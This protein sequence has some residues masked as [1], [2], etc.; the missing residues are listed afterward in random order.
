MIADLSK[1]NTKLEEQL[2]VLRNQAQEKNGGAKARAVG[3][4]SFMLRWREGKK[5]PFEMHRSCDAVVGN[6]IVYCK[7]KNLVNAYHIPSSS[8]SPSPKLPS[9]NWNG[10][11]ITMIDGV[12][13]TVGG[14]RDDGKKDT[15]K[16]LSLT[17]EE[18]WWTEKFPPMPTN[19]YA[20]SVLCTGTALIVA[21]GVNKIQRLKTVEVLNI[22]T[23][24]WHFAPGLPRPLSE[25]SLTQCGDLI[26]LLGGYTEDGATNLVYSCLSSSLLSTGSNSLGERL[27]S[28]LT[29]S[30]KRSTWNRVADLPVK[31]S[32][33]VTLCGRLLAIGG[34]DSEGQPST[35]IHMYLPTTD[36]WE[37]ISH[38]TTPRSCCLAA[39]LPDNQLMVVGGYTTGGKRCDSVEFGRIT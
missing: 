37:V 13:T 39:V 28:T 21:G 16:L 6:N 20:V 15:N 38:I 25:S 32:T 14:Y 12:L 4:T 27:V 36:S 1:Q 35:A 33:A 10:F 3:R 34:E 29:R 5:A 24:Q 22:E 8:W 23:R 19:R 18:R 2:S 26:Y 30:S 9:C 17:R 7:Y 11:A 31:D